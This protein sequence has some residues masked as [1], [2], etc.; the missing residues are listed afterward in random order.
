M[1]PAGHGMCVF[2]CL[3]GGVY[4]A[5]LLWDSWRQFRSPGGSGKTAADLKRV[6]VSTQVNRV[7]QTVVAGCFLVVACSVLIAIGKRDLP[8]LANVRTN[9]GTEGL[10]VRVPGV[11]ALPPRR[12][13][14]S[15]EY[16]ECPIFVAD[17][18]DL[19]ITDADIR[20]LIP[21]ASQL[22]CLVL[23][24]TKITDESLR[25]ITRMPRVTALNLTDTRITNTGLN[26]LAQ[27]QTLEVLLLVRTLVTDKELEYLGE[28]KNLKE[29]GLDGTCVTDDGLEYITQMHNL[30]KLSLGGTQITDI[31]L[32]QLSGLQSLR[33]LDLHDTAITDSGLA[34]LDKMHCLEVLH[35]TGT[36]VTRHGVERLMK[37]LPYTACYYYK[38]K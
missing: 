5:W 34:A 8:Q 26:Q 1:N 13:L 12:L 37:H 16:P 17:L 36:N 21:H 3:I 2:I 6:T 4:S 24:N 28:L 30:E 9:G 38:C 20:A 32:R 18:S 27:T 23:I 31:G 14:Y 11:R 7:C 15:N 22:D 19:P 33:Y 29:L 35:L 10:C 25:H